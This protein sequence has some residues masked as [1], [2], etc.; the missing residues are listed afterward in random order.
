MKT[1]IVDAHNEV[2]AYWFRE[3]LELEHPLVVVRIDEHHDMFHECSA[4]PAKEGRTNVEYLAHIISSYITDYA[5]SEINEGNF[6]CAAFHYDIIGALYHFNPRDDEI[7]AYGRI[8]GSKFLDA[9]RTKEIC[10]TFAGK[11]KKWIV[12]DEILTRLRRH[13][14]KTTPSPRKLT[15][16]SFRR[17][18]E[19]N[20]LSVVIC[21]D[22]DGLYGVK[23][24]NSMREVVTKRL[25]K[26]K[27]VLDCVQSPIFAGIARSQTPRRYVPSEIVD[28]LQDEVLNLIFL[29]FGFIL[30]ISLREPLKKSLVK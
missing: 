20:L 12:W 14:G 2:L 8:A 25:M 27:Q 6:T 5:K 18:I 1:A 26:S 29:L 11:R 13:H 9:P 17:E 22:L 28:S 3:R 19:G 23:D 7:N 10:T 4:L 16:D 24:K 15:L 30:G 21:F